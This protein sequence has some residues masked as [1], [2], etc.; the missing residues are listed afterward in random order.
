[1]AASINASRPMKSEKFITWV[2]CSYMVGIIFYLIVMKSIFGVFFISM[3]LVFLN[4]V[5]AFVH[6]QYLFDRDCRLHYLAAF[7]QT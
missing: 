3:N 6:M 7:K 1:M 5:V 2:K 4:F